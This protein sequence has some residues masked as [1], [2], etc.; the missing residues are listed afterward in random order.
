MSSTATPTE[1]PTQTTNKISN[2]KGGSSESSLNFVIAKKEPLNGE[3]L[4]IG[5]KNGAKK[6]HFPLDYLELS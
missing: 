1:I 6:C 3:F 5:P 4:G 2:R